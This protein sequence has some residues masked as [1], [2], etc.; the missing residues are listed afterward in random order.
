MDLEKYY[1]W[2]DMGISGIIGVLMKWHDFDSVVMESRKA[3]V[4]SGVWHEITIKKGEENWHVS[5][6]RLNL[7]KQRFIDVL[8]QHK[9]REYWLNQN[10]S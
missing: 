4:E 3:P 1:K 8:D 7:L 10:K 2:E 6:Q 5:S 9:V